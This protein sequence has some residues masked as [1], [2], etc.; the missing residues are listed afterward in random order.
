MKDVQWYFNMRTPGGRRSYLE[1][2]HFSEF[3]AQDHCTS[4]LAQGNEAIHEVTL[5][6]LIA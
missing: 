2:L 4:L 5:I 3:A 1:R 6:P